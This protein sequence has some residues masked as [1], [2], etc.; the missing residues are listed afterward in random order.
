MGRTPIRHL[1]VHTERVVKG[2]AGRQL[3]LFDNTDYEKLEKLDQAIDSIRKRFG[4]DAV[5]RA[6]FLEQEKIDHM[7]GGI[8]REKRTVDYKKEKVM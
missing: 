7:S 1:G 8:S 5:Q 6:S 2:D 4:M 3:T